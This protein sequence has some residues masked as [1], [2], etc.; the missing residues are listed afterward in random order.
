MVS[1]LMPCSASP[2][3]TSTFYMG[4]IRLYRAMAMVQLAQALEFDEHQN[5]GPLSDQHSKVRTQF[6]RLLVST[7][8]M[9]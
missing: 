9:S 2:S 5:R 3:S 4:V 1:L 6:D 8:C 7:A